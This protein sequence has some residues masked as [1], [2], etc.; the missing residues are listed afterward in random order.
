[1]EGGAERA[2]VIAAI[3]SAGIPVMAHLGLQPQ[4]VHRAGFSVQRDRDRLLSDAKA[5]QQAGAFS[6]LLE[7]I[8]A[9]LA[10]E[11]TAAVSIPTIGIGA[12]PACDGQILVLHDLLGLGAGRLPRHAKAYVDLKTI[13]AEAVTRYRDEVR[14]SEF[15]TSEQSFT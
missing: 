6:V 13:A 12:G 8:P 9:K 15:P 5:V 10:G 2:E 1:M 7:C 14:S 4:A 3:V 11:V